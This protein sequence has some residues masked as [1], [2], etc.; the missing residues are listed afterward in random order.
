MP[1]FEPE[2]SPVVHFVVDAETDVLV[3][4]FKVTDQLK[5]HFCT[6]VLVLH[7]LIGLFQVVVLGTDNSCLEQEGAFE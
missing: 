3:E 1:G 4:H 7:V 6:L 2:Q 5:L